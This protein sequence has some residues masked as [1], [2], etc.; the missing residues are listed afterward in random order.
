MS[1]S[2][3]AGAGKYSYCLCLQGKCIYRA[4]GFK[5]LDLILKE[6]W[7]EIPEAKKKKFTPCGLGKKLR[8]KYLDSRGFKKINFQNRWLKISDLNIEN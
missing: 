8:P 7:S 3:K 1:L 2:T 6:T 5:R 4:D